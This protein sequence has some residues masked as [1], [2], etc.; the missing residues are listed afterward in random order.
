MIRPD[1]QDCR[2]PGC[3][4]NS[5]RALTNEGF[6][7]E[8]ILESGV[9]CDSC[10]QGFD[11]IWGVPFL[12]QFDQADVLSLIEI[13]SNADNYTR[14]N[15]V[16]EGSGAQ[17]IDY[18][19]WQD[20]LEG[21]H[22]SPNREAF[23]SSHCITP[24]IAAWF[25]NRY[26]EHIYFRALTASL[27]LK[28]C[29]ILDVGAG[30]GFDSFKFVRAGSHVT[31]LEFSPILAHEGWRKVPQARWFGGNSNA[32]PFAQG[33]FNLVVANA[34]LHHM[35]DVP[36]AM[37]EMLRVLQPG[38]YL[39]TLCDSYR[40]TGSGEEVEIEVFKDNATVL[41]GVNEGI[42]PLSDFLSVLLRHRDCLDVEV[43]TSEVHGLQP[44]LW[45]RK[46][47]LPRIGKRTLPYPKQWDFEEALKMLPSTSG[48]L[49]LR[50]RL[51]KPIAAGISR[52]AVSA[53]RPGEFSRALAS[54]SDGVA[55]LAGFVPAEFVDLPLLGQQHA[56]F[57]LLNGWKLPASGLRHRTAYSRARS[58]QT[59]HA[60]AGV[61]RLCV[62][63]PHIGWHDK[64]EVALLLNGRT[65][66]R[67]PICRGLWT[68]IVAPVDNL[69]AESVA[70]VEVRL[71]TPLSENTAKLFH[72]RELG[73]GNYEPE[74]SRDESDLEQ[75]GLEALAEIGLLRSNPVRVI[76]STDYALA[77]NSLN[78]LRALGLG[79]EII[80]SRGQESFFS[81]EPGV[82][83][84]GT[85]EET[86]GRSSEPLVVPCDVLLIVAA[87][88]AVATTLLNTVGSPG[89]PACAIAVLPGGAAQLLADEV[90][91]PLNRAEPLASIRT[92]V[93]S[94]VRRALGL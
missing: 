38:G 78:R 45:T 81:S 16:Q 74:R 91:A 79:A 39:L 58:F 47:K 71:D 12:G 8:D 11:V 9:L 40:K 62:L 48:G 67:R 80:I 72:V 54:Q 35:K 22:L 37:E 32:L 86:G 18:A 56:K 44:D 29:K 59:Y 15:A 69:E 10:G 23:L 53:I 19:R 60:G 94:L 24:D 90:S 51:K 28:G 2:C 20:L 46:L 83:I 50:V 64:P 70:A 17:G 3:A 27:H 82:K 84:I 5:L 13:A 66:A 36:A 89:A 21:Y 25:P 57:R 6:D 61:L 4:S 88:C 65:L 31:C 92:A 49:A 75:Y 1:L 43:F 42:P 85:Y 34:A 76:L 93:T 14:K 63:A 77:I 52:R 41:M 7:P 30:P 55:K 87:D 26:A 33:S 73:F 68:E